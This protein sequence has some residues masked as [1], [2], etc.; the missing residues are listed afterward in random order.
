MNAE[1][2]GKFNR[3]YWT[4]GLLGGLLLGAGV[5]SGC[6]SGGGSVQ[7]YV[8][9]TGNNRIVRMDDMK[10]TNWTTCGAGDNCPMASPTGIVVNPSY[11]IMP[12]GMTVTYPS[13]QIYVTDSGN[14]RIVRMDD[15][16][17]TNWTT[18]GTGG[19][20]DGRFN[21]PSGIFVDLSDTNASGNPVNSYPLYVADTGN[22][23]IVWISDMTTGD[24]WTTLSVNPNPPGDA[25]NAPTGIVMTPATTYTTA[26]NV[27]VTPM[28][29]YVTDSGNNRIVRMDDMKGTNWT[30]CGAGD[31]CPMA[32]P[33][34]L[35]VN[36]AN[37]Y[38]ADT[39]NSRIAQMVIMDPD[40]GTPI[41]SG[42]HWV[43]FGASG[44]GANQFN[45]PLDVLLGGGGA[46]YI[47]D[48]GNNRIVRMND[49][50]GTDWTAFGAGG[51]GV[52]QFLGPS[53]IA[54]RFKG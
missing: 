17:G 2:V 16:T 43:T 48:T 40:N 9:D 11:Y 41:L 47:A 24:G 28:H 49:M 5:V 14:N 52:G 20:G 22:N 30:T 51:S 1:V 12:D 44:G 26:N 23:R 42:Y 27:V 54:Y 8:V 36:P 32:A 34:G 10:G 37:L 6:S 29:I 13:L 7:I 39:G 19:S 21:H 25:L 4:A 31:N 38:V 50:T 53:G 18:F 33:A 46:I 35:A 3:R 15:M 45:A